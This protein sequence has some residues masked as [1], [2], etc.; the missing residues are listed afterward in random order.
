M[1]LFFAM[2]RLASVHAASLMHVFLLVL[3]FLVQLYDGA[4]QALVS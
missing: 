2:R 4:V 3:G 1:D